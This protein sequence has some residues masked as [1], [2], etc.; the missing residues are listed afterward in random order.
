MVINCNAKLKEFEKLKLILLNEDQ[1][2]IF[3]GLSNPMLNLEEKQIFLNY[4][5][6]PS[7][8]MLNLIKNYQRA[9]QNKEILAK[10]LINIKKNQNKYYEDQINQRLI[11][12]Y[13]KKFKK[14]VFKN[15]FFWKSH[16]FL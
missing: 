12:K 13:K 4:E 10:S 1:L 2:I 8:K 11:S 5:N 7:I 6:Q 3:E 9:K 16:S 14:K 15:V